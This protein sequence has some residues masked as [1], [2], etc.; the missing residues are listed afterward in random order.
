MQTRL[1]HRSYTCRQ[2]ATTKAAQHISTLGVLARSIPLLFR[3]APLETTILATVLVAQ[4]LIP[5]L[6]L[7]LTKVTV[8]GISTLS[9]Q[10]P[11]AIITLV[12]VWLFAL[13]TG[14]LLSPINQ[15]LQGNVGEKFTAYV[16]LTL[17][18]KAASLP[19]LDFLDNSRFH[20]QLNVL[21]EG[22]R[23]RP[24]NVMVLLVFLVRDMI[25]LVT[26]SGVLATIG[27][28]VPL[29]VLVSAFP[30]GRLTL[31]LRE[32]GWN[33]LIS[34]TPEARA[35]EYESRVALGSQFAADVRLHDLFPW[36]MGRY[37]QAFNAAHST[38]RNVRARQALQVT[39]ASF[40]TLLV[41]GGLFT[42]AL[43]RARSGQ[44]SAGEVVIVVTGLA[45]V[46]QLVFGLIENTGF[47]F[48][49]ILYF[50]M[51]FDFLEL[52]P[53]VK[54]PPQPI[55][56]RDKT[57]DIEFK[58]VS[59]SYPDGR[60]AVS[61]V[62]F[63]L[64][65]GEKLAI[66]G[67]NGAGKTTLVKLLLRYYDVS[68]GSILID[69]IDLRQLEIAAWRSRIG[70]VFQDFGRFSYT[71]RDNIVLGDAHEGDP[72]L[73]HATSLSGVDTFLHSLPEGLESRLG[74]EFGGTEL[75]GGQ[76]QKIALARAIYRDS[77]ILVLDEPT[78]ALDPRSEHELFAQFAQLASGKSA[79]LITHRLGS[80]QMAD[81]IVVLK[82]GQIV[83]EGTHDSLLTYGGEYQELWRMQAGQYEKRMELQ[84]Q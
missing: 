34:R 69:G 21:Q 49:R 79:F 60:L 24:L 57:P 19:G 47:L 38:M 43:L 40:I 65:P 67:E 84:E 70:A 8:D 29:L 3:A 5:A 72:R 7:Y 53:V 10:E 52:D 64:R 51:Y 2:M 76:W 61:G 16:N 39:P 9:F 18:Q 66:V 11:Q 68:S 32:M 46:Q 13:A 28:W 82:A 20:D 12:A 33:A 78:S 63:V 37:E 56:L 71:V 55:T 6:T 4:G 27:W 14:V 36:L 1:A 25:T 75:S 17:M 31:R 44:I 62:N 73:A 45:Q 42:W 74:K 35:M 81:R 50:Q 15:V 48:E 54:D 58:E 26:V 59:F 23:N 80:V 22:A 83:E 77:D 30:H 41:S